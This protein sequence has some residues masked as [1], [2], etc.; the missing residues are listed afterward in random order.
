MMDE[1]ALPGLLAMSFGLHGKAVATMQSLL[2][3]VST[4]ATTTWCCLLSERVL[5]LAMSYKMLHGPHCLLEHLPWGHLL[6]ICE[7]RSSTFV[8][9]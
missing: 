3:M 4:F 2:P 7:G 1:A 8:Q 9:L 6:D 5:K